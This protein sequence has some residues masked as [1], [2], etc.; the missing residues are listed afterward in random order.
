LARDEYIMRSA[1]ELSDGEFADWAGDDPHRW[2]L[3]PGERRDAWLDHLVA[4]IR[5]TTNPLHRNLYWRMAYA[6]ACADTVTSTPLEI[7]A[8]ESCDQ[9][10]TNFLRPALPSGK[11]N[12]PT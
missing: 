5:A 2:A 11:A 4:R 9:A 12:Q 6:V 1:L 3:L 8:T 7:H 10:A